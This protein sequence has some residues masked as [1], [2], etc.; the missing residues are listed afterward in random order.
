MPETSSAGPGA[1]LKVDTGVA[2]LDRR[3][4]VRVKEN[5]PFGTEGYIVPESV[6][7][8]LG[9]MAEARIAKGFDTHKTYWIFSP[10]G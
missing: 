7:L 9:Q 4:L 1:L 10:D 8:K 6:K 3:R 5:V 2:Q